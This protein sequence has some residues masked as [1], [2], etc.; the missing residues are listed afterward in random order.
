M[1]DY[2]SAAI[3]FGSAPASF[4]TSA[5]Y[6]LRLGDILR[7]YFLGVPFHQRVGLA[8]IASV[9]YPERNIHRTVVTY[10]NGTVVR[11]NRS[12][13]AWEVGGQV[14]GQYG[15]TVEGPEFLELGVMQEGRRVDLVRT[16]ELLYLDMRG[17]RGTF[18]G[19]TT[20][21]RVAVEVF[22]DRCEVMPIAEVDSIEID[23]DHF[24]VP[25]E[26]MGACSLVAPDGSVS[27]LAR[28]ESKALRVE[29]KD[30]EL[31]AG[32]NVRFAAEYRKIV[33]RG[34]APTQPASAPTSRQ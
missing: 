5:A 26:R 3:L 24:V 13:E 1:D 33:L 18:G 32:E 4:L 14:L 9:V 15:Y 6:S 25:G 22:G 8:G 29:G 31:P 27:A 28:G 16:K 34:A 7:E 23:P 11:V 10:A 20:A 30:L 17:R 19:V 21:G 2:R 12:A